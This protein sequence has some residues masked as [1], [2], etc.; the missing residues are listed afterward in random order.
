M[1]IG[2]TIME[3]RER[4]N[5]TQERFAELLLVSRQTV[6]NWET[7][8]CV[9]DIETL[10]MMSEK[11]D[12]SLD[13]LLGVE[14][15]KKFL[16]K[17]KRRYSTKFKLFTIG[18]IIASSLL[19]WYTYKRI[20]V[21]YYRDTLGDL[22]VASYKDISVTVN[23]ELAN[24]RFLGLNVYI[25]TDVE[26][27]EDD[28]ERNEHKYFKDGL[29]ALWLTKNESFLAVESQQNEHFSK[30]GFDYKKL[31]RKYNFCN[32]DQLADYYFAHRY[33]E[34]SIFWSKN[35]IQ[36]HYL[37][38]VY[39][40]GASGGGGNV[41]EIAGDRIDGYVYDNGSFYVARL[42]FNDSTYYLRFSRNIYNLG[43]VKNMLSGVYIDNLY[44]GD[45]AF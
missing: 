16:G 30:F 1:K 36:M 28:E 2:K 4:E 24:E 13:G 37:A 12:I 10:R 40:R 5:L 45:A 26:R 14:R 20:L 38:M 15:E 21:N 29:L 23:F 19:F 6:S 7:D 31:L 25:P 27:N 41:Y 39:M 42:D 3:I 9:P 33:E 35:K 43:A 44:M 17:K 22:Y 18:I 8:K 34:P 11:F 32:E